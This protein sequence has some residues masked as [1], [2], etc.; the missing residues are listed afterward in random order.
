M[1]DD[2][3]EASWQAHREAVARRNRWKTIADPD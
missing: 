1:T 2:D 3:S